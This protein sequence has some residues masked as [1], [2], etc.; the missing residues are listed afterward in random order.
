MN[1]EEILAEHLP[2]E[3]VAQEQV[4][5]EIVQEQVPQVPEF[6]PESFRDDILNSV[7][8]KFGGLQQTLESI[9]EQ[10]STRNIPEP[11]EEEMM[12]AQIAEML[13]IKGI[14][15]QLSQKDEALRQVQE[16]LQKVQQVEERRSL[17]SQ[18]ESIAK[19]NEGFSDELVIGELEEIAKINPQ[20]AQSLNNPA[21]WEYV[22]KNKFAS[23]AGSTPDPITASDTSS[24][25]LE[26]NTISRFKNGEQTSNDIGNL[27]YQYAQ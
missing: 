4:P 19:R 3:E 1:P 17:E 23:S 21:G 8:E 22:W 10:N 6:N 18:V 12:K 7:G 14:Q 26:E 25:E 27:L 20:L 13:G 9:K 5:Q 11:S 16:Q 2:Q 24:G 15:D